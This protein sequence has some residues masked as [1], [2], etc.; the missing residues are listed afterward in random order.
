MIKIEQLK[1]GA[2]ATII[3]NGVKQPVYL[4]MNITAAE[5]DTLEVVGG[6]LVYTVDEAEILEVQ[7]GETPE[8]SKS[9]ET[10]TN[11]EPS[12]PAVETPS[13]AA[14]TVEVVKPAIVKPTPRAA[15]N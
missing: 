10:T 13:E 15:K 3:R 4:A 11:T 2:K 9:T 5:L 8:P 6:S 7:G 12:E 1:N 14:E